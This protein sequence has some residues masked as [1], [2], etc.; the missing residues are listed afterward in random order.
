MPGVVKE[1]LI[2]TD[3]SQDCRGG[4]TVMGPLPGG[5]PM[6]ETSKS[7]LQ[8]PSSCTGMVTSTEPPSQ[9]SV[10]GGGGMGW[11]SSTLSHS[12]GHP[13]QVSSHVA[14]SKTASPMKTHM[15]PGLGRS[16]HV[17][18]PGQAADAQEHSGLA[19]DPAELLLDEMGGGGQG[20]A[21]A[22]SYHWHTPMKSHHGVNVFSM[23]EA[24]GGLP[25]GR[26]HGSV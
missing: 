20:Q 9:G 13:G 11:G 17:E 19:E 5:P 21:S 16:V 10:K 15:K 12:I 22:L 4:S 6:R 24:L 23:Q 1:V 2:V 14:L 18:R 25:Q 3:D 7:L 26:R 8:V